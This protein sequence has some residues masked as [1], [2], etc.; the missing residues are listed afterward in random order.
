MHA[1]THTH[2]RTHTNTH[3][4][5]HSRLQDLER[6]AK[7]GPSFSDIVLPHAERSLEE[8]QQW[9]HAYNYVPISVL[10]DWAFEVEPRW[11]KL[12]QVRCLL[13]YLPARTQP[14]AG[15]GP[16][17]RQALPCCG[18]AGRAGVKRPPYAYTSCCAGAQ[19]PPCY[20]LQ[21]ARALPV[22]ACSAVLQHMQHRELPVSTAWQGRVQNVCLVHPGAFVLLA[23]LQAMLL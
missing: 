6:I 11:S 4:C 21:D 19:K 5:A 18:A 22:S 3:K 20:A 2:T 9:A 7:R 16:G 13:R 17:A 14:E 10:G 8:G 23:E 15:A 12:D 1:C